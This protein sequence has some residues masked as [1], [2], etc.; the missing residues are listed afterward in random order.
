MFTNSLSSQPILQSSLT[1]E[2]IVSFS[3]IIFKIVYMKT[4][5]NQKIPNGTKVGYKPAVAAAM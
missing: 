1:S 3:A 5:Q 4:K 2:R